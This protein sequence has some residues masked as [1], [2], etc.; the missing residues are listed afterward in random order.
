MTVVWSTPG[1]P[2]DRHRIGGFLSGAY[3]SFSPD[4]QTLLI[5]GTRLK[6]DR[7][8]YLFTVPASGGRLHKISGEVLT[9]PAAW[10]PDGRWIA[11]ANYDGNVVML[12]P[13][14]GG[15]KTVVHLSG[16]TASSPLF[17]SNSVQIDHLG[18][19]RSGTQIV[20]RAA[21]VPPET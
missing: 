8:F 4:R 17:G 11:A 19:S 10:S 15:Q 14:G 20:F 9:E 7:R 21:K 3:V 2:A 16:G 6:G 5:G 12:Q 13:N 18:W 1:H